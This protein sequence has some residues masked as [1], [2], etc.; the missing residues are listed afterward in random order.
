MGYNPGLPDGYMGPQTKSAIETFQRSQA[1]P[2]DGKT[3][4]DLLDVL[5]RESGRLGVQD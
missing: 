3:S 2:V 5:R 1:L 4:Q